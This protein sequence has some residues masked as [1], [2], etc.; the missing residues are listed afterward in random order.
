MVVVGKM[1]VVVD[2]AV[3]LELLLLLGPRSVA[4]EEDL[5]VVEVGNMALVVGAA[6]VMGLLLLLLLLLFLRFVLPLGP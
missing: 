4:P 5:V 1:N 2:A 6:V 3:V